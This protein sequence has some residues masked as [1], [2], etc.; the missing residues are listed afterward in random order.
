MG[1]LDG[2]W[3]QGSQG[4]ELRSQIPGAGAIGMSGGPLDMEMLPNEFPGEDLPVFPRSPAHFAADLLESIPRH[5]RGALRMGFEEGI[6]PGPVAHGLGIGKNMLAL[7]AKTE[8][9]WVL[10]RA[11]DLSGFLFFRYL[12]DSRAP[13]AMTMTSMPDTSSPWMIS[14]RLCMQGAQSSGSRSARTTTFWGLAWRLRFFTKFGIP[15][16]H[17]LEPYYSSD[18]PYALESEPPQVFQ[19]L[20]PTPTDR[21]LTPW[22]PT[23][24]PSRGY[25]FP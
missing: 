5:F 10:T 21:I 6:I 19:K 8:A 3:D 14:L 15:R 24:D 16:L 7:R 9:G 13:L 17:W 22:S 1:F 4:A 11:P 2:I 12:Q 25:S 20:N 23:S 18:S